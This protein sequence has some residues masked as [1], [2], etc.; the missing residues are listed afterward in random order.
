MIP[1]WDPISQNLQEKSGLR[2]KNLK[3]G[4]LEVK[5]ELSLADFREIG[6]QPESLNIY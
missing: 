6:M 3:T 5:V 2:W 1:I 4:R